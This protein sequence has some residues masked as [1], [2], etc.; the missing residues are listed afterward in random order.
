MF[1]TEEA[2]DGGSEIS[3]KVDLE[4]L[5]LYV[6]AGAIVPMGP[7]VQYVDEI[8]DGPITVTV[9]PGADGAFD[10]YEDDGRS[11]AYKRG[12]WTGLSMKWSDGAQRLTVS[13]TP[14]SRRPATPR[15]LVLRVVG[16]SGTAS[17]RFTGE[18]LTLRV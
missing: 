8:S 10:L 6:R 18:P 16:R 5:P 2:V 4:T 15:E 11:F 1:W 9:Y 14:R 13:L 17:A 12:E 7:A 3:R